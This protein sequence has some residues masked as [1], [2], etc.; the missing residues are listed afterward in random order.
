MTGWE[1]LTQ[2]TLRE[3]ETCDPLYR[4]TNFWGPGVQALLADLE[5]RGLDSFKSWPSADTWFY[6]LYGERLT[7]EAIDQAFELA[8]VAAPQLTRRWFGS[9]LTG[10]H[11]ARRDFDA[12][13]LAWDQARWPFDLETW[14]ESELG[15]PRQRFHLTGSKAAAWTR[16]YLNYLLCLA[17]LS[18]YVDEPPTSFLEIGGG[19]G[20]LGEIVLS[21]QVEARYVDLDIPPLLTVASFYL[22]SLFPGRVSLYGD[23]IADVGP[24]AGIGSACLPSWRIDDLAGP[25]DVFVNSY[26]FQEMEPDV[27]ERY[28][29]RVAAKDV[30]WVVS[31]NSRR[32]KPTVGEGHEIGVLEPVTS[33]RIVA[34][35]AEHGYELM[36]AHGDP[37]IHAAGELVVL[38]RRGV[39]TRPPTPLAPRPERRS[40]NLAARPRVVPVPDGSPGSDGTGRVGRVAREWLPPVLLR[41]LRAVRPRRRGR[42]PG[43]TTS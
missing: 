21:R 43:G 34:L 30:S 16:P 6:P 18:R 41:R 36:G 7:D 11:Q 33:A 19:Y 3:V 25:F 24:I 37:L 32:G 8:Q 9:A 14:G 1:D 2:R 22:D 20:V 23:A 26:S 4:P 27:V 17:A 31:L 42:P 5:E 38:R 40:A 39:V 29:S 13:R 15:Q 12:V 35:F 10:T 28:V